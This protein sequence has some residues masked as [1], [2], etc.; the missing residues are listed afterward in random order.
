MPRALTD[1]VTSDRL[2]KREL[3][4]DAVDDLAMDVSQAMI[5]TL[6]SIGE[7]LM[8]DTHQLHDCGL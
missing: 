5:T 4:N 8:V 1:G 6:K 7:L 3:A 2:A